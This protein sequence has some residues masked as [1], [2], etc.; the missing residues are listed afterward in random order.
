MIRF[1][2]TDGP[3]ISLLEVKHSPSKKTD[4]NINQLHDS[5]LSK[6]KI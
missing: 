4:K 2:R 3:D 1:N 6:K 5:Y